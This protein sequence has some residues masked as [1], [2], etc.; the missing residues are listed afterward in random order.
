MK[1]KLI[2]FIIL[3]LIFGALYQIYTCAYPQLDQD[4]TPSDIPACSFPWAIFPWGIIIIL[5][6]PL[7]G[8]F[9][10]V[11]MQIISGLITL[12]AFVLTVLIP[13]TIFKKK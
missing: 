9:D 4:G 1:K 8:I 2:T 10:L 5:S 7:F 11:Y 12:T 6:W 3:Y 13:H